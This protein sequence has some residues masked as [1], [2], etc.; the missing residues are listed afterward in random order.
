MKYE[1]LWMIKYEACW[2][3]SD[4]LSTLLISFLK[5]NTCEN[6][7]ILKPVTPQYIAS[8][9]CQSAISI[10]LNNL[11]HFFCWKKNNISLFNKYF[12]VFMS[13]L[14]WCEFLGLVAMGLGRGCKTRTYK[15]LDQTDYLIT[16]NEINI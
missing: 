15:K 3:W 16:E 5:K 11:L 10:I 14:N 4:E 6:N 8:A 1:N 7:Y 2:M 13:F 9:N 12:L